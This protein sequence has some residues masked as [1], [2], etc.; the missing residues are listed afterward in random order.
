M[1][2]EAFAERVCRTRQSPVVAAPLQSAAAARLSG[3]LGF[4][5][6]IAKRLQRLGPRSG[7][8]GRQ[9]WGAVS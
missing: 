1:I 8:G 7:I 6:T 5:G 3:Q 2:V 4:R 9:E